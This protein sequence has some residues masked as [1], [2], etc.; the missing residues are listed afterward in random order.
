MTSGFSGS[1]ALVPWRNVGDREAARSSRTISRNAVGGAH[2]VVIGYWASVRSAD[3]GS[4]L[5]RES[6]VKTHA[7]ACHGPKKL[8]HAA[9][10]QPVSVM[11]QWM[12]LGL[13]SSQSSPVILCP[14]P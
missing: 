5:P 10:A 9:L 4:N 2:H 6:T 3:A 7:P 14:R 11:H 13:R 1:P 8:E 12:S